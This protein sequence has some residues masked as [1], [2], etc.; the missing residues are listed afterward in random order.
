[1]SFST[2][3]SFTFVVVIIIL[4]E[5]LFHSVIHTSSYNVLLFR[6]LRDSHICM[7]YKYVRWCLKGFCFTLLNFL[8]LLFNRNG[9]KINL[10]DVKKRVL[11]ILSVYV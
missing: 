6:Q 10:K 3:F 1:M 7:I 11:V 4:L 2:W 9:V 8:I 5:E